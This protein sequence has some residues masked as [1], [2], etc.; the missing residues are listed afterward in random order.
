MQFNLFDKVIM[1]S[2]GYEEILVKREEPPYM[3]YRC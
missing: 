2:N 3:F 1:S